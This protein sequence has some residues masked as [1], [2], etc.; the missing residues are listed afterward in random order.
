M[1]KVKNY[2]HFRKE[3][4]I[5]GMNVK[6]FIVFIIIVICS[7]MTLTTGVSISKLVVLL[8]IIGISYLVC[9]SLLSNK[10]LFA[11]LSDEKLPNKISKY[12]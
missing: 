6:A 9:V 4:S 1:K 7:L 2:R 12:E 3:P 8:L 10:G 11:S 5:W